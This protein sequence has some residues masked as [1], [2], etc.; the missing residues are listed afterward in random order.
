MTA[1][2]LLGLMSTEA[3]VSRGG[4]PL[5]LSV[6]TALRTIRDAMRTPRCRRRRGDLRT[7]LADTIKDT[8]RRRRSKRARGW[9]HE[10]TESPPDAPKIRYGHKIRLDFRKS[11]PVNHLR[12]PSPYVPAMVT[13]SGWILHSS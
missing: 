1:L 13:K 5:S 9:A 12:I 7:E 4:D 11:L 6:G 8:Y 3:I 2:L 10:K